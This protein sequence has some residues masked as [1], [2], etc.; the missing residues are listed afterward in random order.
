MTEDSQGHLNRL[1]AALPTEVRARLDPHLETVPLT[2]RT[3]LAEAGSRPRHAYFLHSGV[4]CL[5]APTRKGHAEAATV[6]PEG[7]LGFEAV[8]GGA[9]KQ[10]VLV[11]VGGVASRLPI[12]VLS[13]LAEES[14]AFRDLLLAY[15]RCFMVQVLQS[16]ACNGLHSVQERCARWLL[17][18]HDR[19]GADHFEM[20]HQF[21]GDLVGMQRP[22][23]SIAT[24]A[25]RRAELI[26]WVRGKVTI[27]NRPGLESAAC[28]CY[29]IVREAMN[30]NISEATVSR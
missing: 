11:Q 25:L 9:I 16:V 12:E 21:L 1:I 22:S 6:G 19:A 5:M 18:T 7:F 4:V 20:T 3:V 14:K 17:M 28:E 10:R 23:V 29:G 15:V 24:G 27:L 30:E 26:R 13:D 2:P 8:L